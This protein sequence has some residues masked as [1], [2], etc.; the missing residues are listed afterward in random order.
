VLNRSPTLS[1][2]N[3]TP[4]EAWSGVKPSVAHFRVFGC[5]SHVHVSDSKRTKL[6]D[7]SVICVLLGVSE[8]SKAYRLYDPNSQKIVVSRDIV[9]EEDKHWEWEKTHEELI[10]VDLELENS[11]A[12]NED[13][14]DTVQEEVENATSDGSPRSNEGRV[15][16]PPIWM[17]DY[18]SGERLSEEED[19]AYLVMLAADDPICFE[20]AV[21]DE[22]WRKAMDAEI[23]AIEKNDTWELTELPAEGKKI[24]VKWV[25]RTKINENGEVD[26][27]K[28]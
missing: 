2:R 24:G 28:A 5:I 18:A 25:Y 23:K 6:D 7:K 16:M 13:N 4:K 14:E 19:V 15:R 17:R 1:V 26:K 12:E 3:K 10:V 27:Y 20:D 22:K 21:K 11:E 8:E 9:F